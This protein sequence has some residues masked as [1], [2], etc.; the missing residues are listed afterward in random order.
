MSFLEKL[1]EA[2]IGFS[3]YA[4]LGRDPRG[5]FGYMA[6][7]LAI[8][9]AI[10][11][12]LTMVDLR[13][14]VA[15]WATQ[16]EKWPDFGVRGGQFYFEGPMPF[17]QTLS[18]GTLLVIDTTGQ[19]RPESLAGKS[20]YLVT[21][22]AL[23]LIQPGLP[24]REFLFNR[25]RNDIGKAEFQQFLASRPER[26]VS[27]VYLFIYLFQLLFKAIDASVLALIAIFYGS[28]I[29]RPVS[30]EL[31]F[32]MALY[33]MSLPVIIQWVF[34]DFTAFSPLGFTIWW[35]VATIYLIFGLRAYFIDGEANPQG[36]VSGH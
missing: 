13:Q 19:T 5:G 31:G 30:F 26:L 21:R 11:G 16:V 8:V 4:R 3:G 17:S 10:N 18:D 12:Y 28:M 20:A 34:R 25:L 29:R 27:F 35:S 23:Y 33:A 6:V 7:L 14:H 2:T 36:P 22:E 1:K 32:K 9:L 15:A 24:H